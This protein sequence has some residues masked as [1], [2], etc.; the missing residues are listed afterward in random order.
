[1]DFGDLVYDL[2]EVGEDE[3]VELDFVDGLVVANG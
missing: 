2:V 3:I 1:M